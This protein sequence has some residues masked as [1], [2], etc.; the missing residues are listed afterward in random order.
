[1]TPH[2]QF[3]LQFPPPDASLPGN[4]PVHLRAIGGNRPLRFMIDDRLLLSIPA[5][6]S[7]T[8]QPP[9][10][11]YYHLIVLDTQGQAISRTLHVIGPGQR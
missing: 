3:T 9:G 8:W 4:L 1:M 11:G 5:L 2:T 6:R 7:V 10:P